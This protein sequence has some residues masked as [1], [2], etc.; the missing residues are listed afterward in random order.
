[1]N[2]KYLLSI[3]FIQRLDE[4]ETV[5]IPYSLDIASDGRLSWVEFSWVSKWG[6]WEKQQRAPI[7]YEW[8][9]MK[10]NICHCICTLAISLFPSNATKLS[11]ILNKLI[12][13][14]FDWDCKSIRIHFRKKLLLSTLVSNAKA[15]TGGVKAVKRELYNV[16]M[17]KMTTGTTT[18]LPVSMTVTVTINQAFNWLDKI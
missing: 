5:V 9:Q 12:E 8:Q 1:M 6:D 3:E 4:M 15:H 18:T 16:K 2:S 10:R 17:T 7:S 11:R 13:L 14:P